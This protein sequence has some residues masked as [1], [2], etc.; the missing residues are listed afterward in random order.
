MTAHSEHAPHDAQ[1]FHD[2]STPTIV[3]LKVFALLLIFLF[4]TVAAAGLDLTKDLPVH[5]PGMNV[6]VML[7]IATVKASLV[8][9]Y[10]MEV[11]KGTKLTWLWAATGFVWVLLLFL[12]IGDYATRGFTVA[13]W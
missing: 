6:I 7:L 13:G 1:E 4:T 10:F 2:H 12:I 3:F 5:I 11:K 9:L 8:V